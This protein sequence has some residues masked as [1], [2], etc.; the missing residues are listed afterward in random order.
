MFT[1]NSCFK[2]FLLNFCCNLSAFHFLL[3]IF[4]IFCRRVR[5][6]V[7]PFKGEKDD[8]LLRVNQLDSFIQVLLFEFYCRNKLMEGFS[9]GKLRETLEGWKFTAQLFKHMFSLHSTQ[10]SFH[11]HFPGNGKFSW[12]NRPI[13]VCSSNQNYFHFQE[14]FSLKGDSFYFFFYFLHF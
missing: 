7:C 3:K 13:Y 8:F 1:R 14:E 5:H 4:V 2:P 10:R 11:F 9:V 12:K 6:F